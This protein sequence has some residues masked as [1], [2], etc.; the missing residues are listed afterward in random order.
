[1]A[2]L[3]RTRKK[4]GILKISNYLDA[5]LVIFL[6]AESRDDA[7][8]TLVDEL[9]KSG[10]LPEKKTFFKAILDR[11]KIVSTG[12]GMGVALPH[13]KLK[14]LKEF[15]IIIGIQKTQGLDWKSLDKAPVRIIF[16]I[17]GPD[18]RSSEYLQILS[19]LTQAIKDEEIRKKL[20]KAKSSSEVIKLFENF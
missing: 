18:D 3:E 12:I 20:L 9:G 10:K 6:Q 17:G 7:L 13:A 19:R 4:E 11:E 16:L 5:H 1:M 8:Q 2:T 14:D 15:F